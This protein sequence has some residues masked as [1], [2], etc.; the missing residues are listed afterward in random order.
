[1]SHHGSFFHKPENALR[2]AL[3]L[4]NINQP[5]AALTLLH[6]VLSSRR[7]KTWSPVYEQVMILYLDL[8]LRRNK[9]REAK[10]GLHQYRNLSQ[11]QAPGSLE[12]VIRHL[13]DKAEEKCRMAK[14]HADD[15]G[16]IH[17]G[18]S[19]SAGA[20]DED[21]EQDQDAVDDLTTHKSI[22]LSTMSL[23]PEKTQRET[24]VVLPSIKFLWEAYRAVLDIL[25]SNSKLEHLYHSAASGALNFCRTYKRRTEFRRFCDMLRQHLG[26]LQKYGSNQDIIDSKP[27][28]KVRGWEGWTTESIEFHL[29]TRFQQLQTASSLHL[30]TEGFRTVEDIYNILQISHVQARKNITSSLPKAKLMATY[31]EKLT[32]LFWVSEN[33][34]FHAFAWYKYYTLCREY[35][36]SMSQDQKQLMA[37]TV[38][39]ATL[40]IPDTDKNVYGNQGNKKNPTKKNDQISKTVEDDMNNEK[41]ARMATLLGFHTSQPTRAGLL[42]ELNYKNL[43]NDVP[44]YLRDLYALLEE[45]TDPLVMVAHARPLLDRLKKETNVVIIDENEDEE[46]EKEQT[47]DVA[48]SHPLAQYVKPLTDVLLLKLLSNLSAA[49]HTVSLD[50]LRKLTTDLGLSFEDVEQGIVSSTQHSKTFSVRID[51]RTKCLRF[52]SS[53][54][55]SDEMRGQ[56][57][58]LAKQLNQVCNMIEIPSE[59]FL[60]EKAKQRHE[61]FFHIQ[62]QLQKEHEAVLKRKNEI[63]KRKEEVERLAQEKLREQKR[64]KYEKETA[65]KLE[66]QRRLAREQKMREKEKLIKIQ[67]EIEQMEKKKYLKAMGKNT[68]EMGAEELETI[69]TVKLMKEH[70]NVANKKK[71]EAERKLKEAVKK[72]DYMVRAVRIEEMPLVKSMFEQKVKKDRERYETETVVKAKRARAQWEIDV[73]EKELLQQFALFDFYA[74]FEK[75]S[76]GRREVLHDAACKEAEHNAEMEADERKYKRAVKRKEDEARAKADE[77]ARIKG[78][79]EKQKLDAEKARKEEERMKKAAEEEKR[80]QEEMAR[81]DELQK[82]EREKQASE[83]APPPSRDLDAASSGKYQARR[84]HEGSSDRARFSTGGGSGRYDDSRGGG[85]GG[86]KYSRDGGGGGYGE[87][88]DRDGGGGGYG[89]RRERDGGGGGYGERRDRDGGRGGGYGDGRER[90]RS[91]G[92]GNFRDR[93]RE[94][95]G[96]NQRGSDRPEPTRNSRW[97]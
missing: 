70:A 63:E 66:E 52:G 64:A 86:G 60:L 54:L 30:Y 50:H 91:S 53:S 28:S 1:M 79:Q 88:R 94:R 32:D 58:V 51:H 77:A 92:M 4:Q 67:K 24:A 87:R 44:D 39:L 15:V 20:G 69:D 10:D 56:L 5:D 26:N 8:C 7:H 14:E 85:Y 21:A 6:D 73:K 45:S 57:T 65:A 55:E 34:L 3:E 84:G 76:M 48:E 80:R 68:E 81:N 29:Q 71:E 27:N 49:Y 90:E 72:L 13:L 61:I 36:K 59:D 93:D 47:E 31:Y 9:S 82:R 11:S 89:E 25:R 2:R 40:C 42:E 18:P 17:D 12:I 46:E 43:L 96:G 74:E 33:Y 97:N 16:Q 83:V 22:M 78:E 95:D 35:N 38:L 75:N 23:D 37:S 62:S 41:T 19:G